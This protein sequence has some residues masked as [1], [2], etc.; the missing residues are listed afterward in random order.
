MPFLVHGMNADPYEAIV[1]C[2]AET[3]EYLVNYARSLIYTTAL[4]FPFLAAI[5]AV[6]ELLTSGETEPVRLSFLWCIRIDILVPTCPPPIDTPSAF[7]ADGDCCLES[8]SAGNGP[9]LRLAHFLSTNTGPAAAGR[10]LPA[11]GVHS[12]QNH[13]AYCPSGQGAG[14]GL[15]ARGKYSRRDQWIG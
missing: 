2:C 4:G 7:P 12:A 10:H 1:L 15:L 8:R 14:P 9:L 11:E 6:Y 5:R 3:R 13:A